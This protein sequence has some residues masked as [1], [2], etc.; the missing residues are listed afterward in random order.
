[1]DL[2]IAGR[3]LWVMRAL[4]FDDLALDRD[5]ELAAQVLC[6]GMSIARVFFIQNDL[7]KAVA[8]GQIDKG[9]APN[10]KLSSLSRKPPWPGRMLA[11][12]L[13]PAPR[14]I[15]LS[16]RSPSTPAAASTMASGIEHLKGSS[17]K[18]QIVAIT[19]AAAAA[20]R[21]PMRPSTV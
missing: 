20:R 5:D 1:M 12:S 19:A 13:A 2:D 8:G 6:L 9:Q 7:C 10:S 16:A 18:N 15:A 3:K 17:G 21:P 4:A 14:F 11:A